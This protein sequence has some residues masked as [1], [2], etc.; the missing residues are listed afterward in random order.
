M[1]DPDNWNVSGVETCTWYEEMDG[2]ALIHINATR[3]FLMPY[4][5]IRNSFA[6]QQFVDRGWWSL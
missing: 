2:G 6:L 4:R 5:H 1:D 3:G